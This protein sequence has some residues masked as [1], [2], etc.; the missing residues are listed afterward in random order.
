MSVS[1]RDKSFLVTHLGFSAVHCKRGYN[2]VTDYKTSRYLVAAPGL[3]TRIISFVKYRTTP[4]LLFKRQKVD[5]PVVC[6]RI[7]LFTM[8]LKSIGLDNK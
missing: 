1:S 5:T 6:D 8:K 2:D 4:L 7:N 3:W